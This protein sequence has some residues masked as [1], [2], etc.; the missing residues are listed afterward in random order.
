MLPS[1][2]KDEEMK[3]TAQPAEYL[4]GLVQELRKQ[5]RET[6]WLE[7]KVDDDEPQAIGEYVSALSN[8]ACLQGKVNAYVVVGSE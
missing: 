1:R 6:E 5:P 7:F 2:T 8:S 4:R 3:T